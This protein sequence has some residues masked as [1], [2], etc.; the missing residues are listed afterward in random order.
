MLPKIHELPNEMKPRERLV[1]NGERSLATYELLAILLGS[2]SKNRSVLHLA[3]DILK[4]FN[5]LYALK[6]ATYQ[7]LLMIKGIGPA[8]AVELRAAIELGRRIYGASQEKMGQ[9]T[10]TDQAGQFFVSELHEFQQEQV[11]VM[12]L[13]TKN[14]IIRYQTLFIGSLN[15]SVAHP[16][17]IFR[18]GVRLAAARLIVGHN[19]PSGDPSP[20]QAD[21]NFTQRLIANGELIG[22]E[23]L[24]H[25]IVGGL[26]FISLK[27]MGHM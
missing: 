8:K 14:Q 20:S 5:S 22:I 3:M 13:N 2:G 17:E 23:V 25:I 4:S 16:R 12:Y 21:I 27:E 1:I 15:M 18:E 7:D 26:D 6:Q 11:H 19:H 10:S 24:D 9:I